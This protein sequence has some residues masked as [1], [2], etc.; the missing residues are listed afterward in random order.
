MN[1]KEFFQECREKD[2]FKN[3]SIYIV[4][5]WVFLQVFALISEPL[6]FPKISLTYLLLILIIGFPIYVYFIWRYRIKEEH[7]EESDAA[8]EALGK[9]LASSK[10][11]IEIDPEKEA[12]TL[13][14]G[15]DRKFRKMYFIGLSVIVLLSAL[16]TLFIVRNNL[17][18][19]KTPYLNSLLE[20]KSTD[21]IAILKFDNNT[22]DEQYDMVG[23]IAVDWIM[24]GITQ[25]KVGE[26]ISP[27]LVE[28]YS[29][30]LKASII[31]S[32]ENGILT[33][34]LKPSKV[35]IGDYYLNKGNL[36]IQASLTDSNMDQTLMTFAPVECNPES[37]LDCIESLKQRVLGYLITD[38]DKKNNLQERPPTY[39]AYKSLLLAKEK[40]RAGESEEELRLLN[41]AIEEDS[42][43]FEPKVL[44]VAYYYNDSDF[45]IADSLLSVLSK[46]STNNSRQLDL[47]NFYE[48]MLE[49]NNRNT[50]FYLQKEYNLSPRDPETNYSMM[51]LAQ[52][53]VNMPQAVDT[54]YEKMQMDDID[55]DKC[56]WCEFRYYLK[57]LADLEL[58][59]PEEVVNLVAPFSKT[60][61]NLFLKKI[62]IKAYVM[63]GK[64]QEVDDLVANFKLV[65][66][67]DDW[68]DLTFYTAKEFLLVKDEEEAERYF[69]RIM[70]T[71]IPD[72]IKTEYEKELM[73]ESYFFARQYPQAE[74]A[75]KA[76]LEGRTDDIKHQTYLAI[77]YALT[78]R[79]AQATEVMK[80]IEAS[81]APFQYGIVD[82]SFAQYYGALGNQDQALNYLLKA[83]AAGR[84]YLPDNYQ[85]DI[86]LQDYKEQPKFKKVM[87]FWH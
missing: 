14:A 61:G 68:G 30:I 66:K 13:S 19:D 44:R 75:L 81:R 43:Y 87:Q 21:K 10:S 74:K 33:E 62:L 82:Y 26:V 67:K 58:G 59:R 53:F 16:S 78:G 63:L 6:G 34:Y 29:N 27:K 25:Y 9:N 73:A 31:P 50:F 20:A 18:P 52:Q 60:G 1:L 36:L 42:T 32:G 7:I 56:R 72:D 57:G 37:P 84:R 51:T 35:I 64:K 55:L 4:S 69:L 76:L 71:F 11:G 77:T 17:L 8:T 47:L 23:K 5:S 70:Q 45:V 79:E 65:A 86:F 85:Y 28:D 12:L 15:I 3:L 22:G 2:V 49:G 48:A 24:H 41:Q 38:K 83:A 46:E 54:I 39:K 40:G 80:R